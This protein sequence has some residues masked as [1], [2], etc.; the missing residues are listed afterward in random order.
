MTVSVI[1][2]GRWTVKGLMALDDKTRGSGPRQV[3]EVMRP[4]S[5][6]THITARMTPTNG[7]GF[8][9][10]DDPD[11]GFGQRQPGGQFYNILPYVKIHIAM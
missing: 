4:A 10:A 8:R 11:H 5:Q 7:W 2:S 1:V 6:C 9:W 3:Q